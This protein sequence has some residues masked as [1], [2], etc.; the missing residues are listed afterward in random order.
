MAVTKWDVLKLVKGAESDI[1]KI[2]DR[3]REAVRITPSP[4]REELE[5]EVEG[6]LV[7]LKGRYE[8]LLAKV[9]NMSIVGD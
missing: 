8:H 7:E 5:T 9:R 6:M 1:D 4:C 3:L 2:T